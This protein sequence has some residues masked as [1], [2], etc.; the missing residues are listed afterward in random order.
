MLS[1][2]LQETAP[3]HGIFDKTAFLDKAMDEMSFGSQRSV[4]L[5]ELYKETWCNSLCLSTCINEIEQSVSLIRS[6]VDGAPPRQT[7]EAPPPPYS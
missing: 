2:R 3:D 4:K 1:M 5:H 6:P 7:V